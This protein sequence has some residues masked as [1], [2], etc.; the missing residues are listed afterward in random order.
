MACSIRRIITKCW[1]YVCG[2]HAQLD[3]VHM[4]AFQL[5]AGVISY[6]RPIKGAHVEDLLKDL[7][8]CEFPGYLLL[9]LRDGGTTFPRSWTAQ[10][11]IDPPPSKH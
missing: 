2:S 1:Q 6:V 7:E 9:Q 8:A 11:A 3:M 5:L 4:A 10:G